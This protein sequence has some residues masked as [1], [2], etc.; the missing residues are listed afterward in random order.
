MSWNDGVGGGEVVD[1]RETS[2]PTGLT[3][4][5]ALAARGKDIPD[6]Q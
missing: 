2:L 3:Y 5:F 1:H 4:R 6:Q